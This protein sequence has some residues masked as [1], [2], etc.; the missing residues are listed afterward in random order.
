G[1]FFVL[2][3][4]A[5]VRYAEKRTLARYLLV[6]LLF[7]LALLAKPMVVTLPLVLLLL[8]Y[9]PLDR[10]AKKQAVRSLLLEKIPLLS[11]SIA[12]SLITLVA[13]KQAIST[14]VPFTLRVGN[15][16]EA[17]ATY[18]RQ[19]VWPTDLAPLYTWSITSVT[20]AGVIVSVS[21]LAIITTAVLAARR[22][23]FLVTGWFW[24][25][26]MLLPVLGIVQVGYQ[27]HADRYTYL[28]QIGLCIAV[29]WLVCEI[30]SHFAAR[31]V[32]LGSAAAVVIGSLAVLARAQAAY[33]H[34]SVSLWSHTVEATEN[35]E[36][37]QVNLGLAL[38]DQGR[39]DDA[40]SHYAEAIKINPRY[41]QAYAAMAV[42]HFL[43]SDISGANDLLQR[44]VEF[45]PANADAH[46]NLGA[47]LSA[48][49]DARGAV[50][51]FKRA[52]ELRPLNH[53]AAQSLAW[54]FAT[55]PE[56]NLR[57]GSRALALATEADRLTSAS[58]ALVKQ[59]LAAAYAE[60]GRFP[61]AVAAAHAGLVIAERQRDAARVDSIKPQL[62]RYQQGEPWRDQS[63]VP[64]VQ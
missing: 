7:A 31:R 21:L 18:L 60:L 1:F 32:V 35:N 59:T 9:W 27:T 38:L 41:G 13:Q 14:R 37:A 61:D 46:Y 62:E 57:D 33:W 58:N 49:G 50:T 28:P 64:A 43:H 11:L 17:V 2:T 44:A 56:S 42:V 36:Y 63:L 20:S 8:D 29:T 55:S 40:S 4:A 54:I 25:L 47:T 53:A 51:H 22:K 3:L 5:Y 45:D 6:L 30:T 15:A 10:F 16:L 39:V 23:R 52:L 19:L 26:A 34:D 24:Y 12:S 48:T